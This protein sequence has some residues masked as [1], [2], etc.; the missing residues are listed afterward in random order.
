MILT[1]SMKHVREIGRSL[2]STGKRI[3]MQGI[4]GGKGKQLAIFLADPDAAVIVGTID[5]WREELALWKAA[6]H[7]VIAK[8]PF[9]PPTDPYFLARTVGIANN[10]SL[11]SEPMTII[12]MSTLISRIR[13]AGYNGII[14]CEDIRLQETI[15]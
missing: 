12:K 7:V 1:T 5:M 15:W 13:S 2:E 14:S 9:D 11:Y 6:R 4:S 10:F 8:L 3:L